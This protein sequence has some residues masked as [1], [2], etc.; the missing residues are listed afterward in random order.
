MCTQ[1]KTLLLPSSMQLGREFEKPCYDFKRRI[2]IATWFAHPDELL[3]LY[4]AMY[5]LT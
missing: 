5:C 1:P 4:V 2:E 3:G